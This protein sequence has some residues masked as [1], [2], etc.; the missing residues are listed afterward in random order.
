M[1]KAAD[2]GAARWDFIAPSKF[3]GNMRAAYGG[4]FNF[5]HG[6]YEYDSAGEDMMGGADVT[7]ISEAY[8]IEVE[9]SHVVPAW[10][11]KYFPPPLFPHLRTPPN[12]PNIRGPPKQA[13][14]VCCSCQM[15]P[16]RPGSRVVDPCAPST[17]ATMLWTSSSR[18]DGFSSLQGGRRASPT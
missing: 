18:R 3:L 7:L 5:R 4:I 12:S 16:L 10:A 6:F 8:G 15:R 9:M 14:L 2:D 17:G 13:L 11:F 1:V